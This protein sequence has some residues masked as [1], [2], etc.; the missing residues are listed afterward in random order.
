MR[1]DHRLGRSM[2]AALQFPKTRHNQPHSSTMRTIL[3]FVLCILFRFRAYNEA[4]LKTPGP[5]LLIP[6]HTSWIDWLLLGVWLDKD[7]KFVVSSLSAQTSWFHHK[8]MINRR[9][10]PID[11]AS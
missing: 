9:T 6:N 7:W 4:V 8:V 5:V 2:V 3:R 10:F 11:N 1:L